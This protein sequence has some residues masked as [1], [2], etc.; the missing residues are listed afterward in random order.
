MSYFSQIKLMNS[1]GVSYYNYGTQRDGR[2]KLFDWYM[3]DTIGPE[4]KAM[5]EKCG[6]TI[7]GARSEYAPEL[8]RVLVCFDKGWRAT[9]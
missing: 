1:A 5:L 2:K 6:A 4:Q 7:R 9:K 8:N 3:V